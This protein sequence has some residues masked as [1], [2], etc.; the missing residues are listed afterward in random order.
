MV[1]Y[2]FGR[3]WTQCNLFSPLVMARDEIVFAS[4]LGG[5]DVLKSLNDLARRVYSVLHPY[6]SWPLGLHMCL[7]GNGALRCVCTM[8]LSCPRDTS[9]PTRRRNVETSLVT[10]VE[11]SAQKTI[12]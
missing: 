1:S 6:G 2:G 9:D 11:V 8:A 10:E 4:D 3:V 5:Q 12:A 7:G